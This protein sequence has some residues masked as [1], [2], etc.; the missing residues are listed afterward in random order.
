MHDK[1]TQKTLDQNINSTKTQEKSK[2]TNSENSTYSLEASLA[3]LFQLLEKGS[4][5]KTHE[6]RYFMKLLGLRKKKDLATYSW[7]MLKDSLIMNKDQ[8]S[9]KSSTPYMKLGILSSGRLSTANFSFHK[10]G[11]ASSL[12]DVLETNVDQKYFLSEKMIASMKA[13]E[14]RHQEKGNS[15]KMSIVDQLLPPTTKDGEQEEQ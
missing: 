14:K 2:P 8:L 15:F 1:F 3:S 7:K 13:H 10:T 11:N 9:P 4:D 12:L 5:L 6:A